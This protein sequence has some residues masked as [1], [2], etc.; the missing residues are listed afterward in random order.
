MAVTDQSKTP[1]TFLEGFRMGQ[2]SHFFVR[3]GPAPSHL[4]HTRNNDGPGPALG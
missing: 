2:V 1:F 3:F 4:P